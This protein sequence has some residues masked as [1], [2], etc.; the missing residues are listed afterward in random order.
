MIFRLQ[1]QI[2]IDTEQR[3]AVLVEQAVESTRALCRCGCGRTILGDRN[4]EF[5][6]MTCRNRMGPR[7][8]KKGVSL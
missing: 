8:I 1:L 6:N 7:L 2:E 4:K 3:R 5:F